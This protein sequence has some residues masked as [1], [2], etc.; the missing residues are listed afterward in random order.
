ME[1]FYDQSCTVSVSVVFMK[2]ECISSPLAAFSWLMVW[3][4]F[5][6]DIFLVNNVANVIK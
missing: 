5:L 2:R 6:H 4:I 1:A 3:K